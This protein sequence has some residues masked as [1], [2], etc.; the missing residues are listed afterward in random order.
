MKKIFLVVQHN[1]SYD[2]EHSIPLKA[3]YNKASA[4]HFKHDKECE[5][6]ELKYIHFYITELEII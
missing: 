4:D 6:V 3:F 1:F 2:N 5:Y